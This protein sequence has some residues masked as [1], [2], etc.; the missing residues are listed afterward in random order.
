M[1][2]PAKDQAVWT[3]RAPLSRITTLDAS[4]FAK[5]QAARPSPG[6]MPKLQKAYRRL[7]MEDFSAPKDYDL[8]VTI[9][10]PLSLGDEEKACPDTALLMFCQFGVAKDGLHG[11]MWP[12]RYKT[13]ARSDCTE[14]NR[15]KAVRIS[16]RLSVCP[17][18]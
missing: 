15:E 9:S 4:H 13:L 12:H 2:T 3:Q 16:K 8:R 18:R 14:H 1:F 7:R 10:V 5:I 11:L 6:L 17:L